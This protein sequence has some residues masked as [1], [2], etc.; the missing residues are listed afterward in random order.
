MAKD[1]VFR[2]EAAPPASVKPDSETM[3]V[4]YNLYSDLLYWLSLNGFTPEYTNLAKNLV[5]IRGKCKLCPYLC[6]EYEAANDKVSERVSMNQLT[7]ALLVS[8]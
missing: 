5:H 8:L 4:D 3:T 1:N 7:V 2:T 6:T